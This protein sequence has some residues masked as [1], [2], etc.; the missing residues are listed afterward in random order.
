MDEHESNT[1]PDTPNAFEVTRRTVIETGTFA[2]G[3]YLVTVEK[4][5]SKVVK[6][7]VVKH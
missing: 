7:V 3:L 2:G 5:A 6:K 1:G 4:G